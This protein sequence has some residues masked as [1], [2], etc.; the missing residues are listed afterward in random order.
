[1][2]GLV[3]SVN[4]D[5]YE[6]GSIDHLKERGMDKGSSRRPTLRGRTRCVFDH[7]KIGTILE[8]TLDRLLG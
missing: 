5:R 8:A 1:M 2:K 7:I 4:T 6:H 3:N